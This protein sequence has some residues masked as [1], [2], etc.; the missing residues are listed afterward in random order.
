MNYHCSTFFLI[1]ASRGQYT[2]AVGLNLIYVHRSSRS[3]FCPISLALIFPS[4]S[5]D[6]NCGNCG[7]PLAF[8]VDAFCPSCGE[9]LETEDFNPY[10]TPDIAVGE[11]RLTDVNGGGESHSLGLSRSMSVDW[12]N[13]GRRFANRSAISV[14]IHITPSVE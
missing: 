7:E 3:S 8:L 9:A 13:G 14:L 6:K 2:W 11:K 5:M 4:A 10:E 12:A 1:T